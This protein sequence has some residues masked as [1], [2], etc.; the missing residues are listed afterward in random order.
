[1]TWAGRVGRHA[2]QPLNLAADRYPVYLRF[3]WG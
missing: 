2:R 1:M 3:I